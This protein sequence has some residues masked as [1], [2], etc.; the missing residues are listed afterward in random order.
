MYGQYALAI[1]KSWLQCSFVLRMSD[2]GKREHHRQADTTELPFSILFSSLLKTASFF[3]V[4]LM[5]PVERVSSLSVISLFLE[6]KW[7]KGRSNQWIHYIAFIVFSCSQREQQK[8]SRK[9]M[10]Y[11]TSSCNESFLN[12]DA[13]S[14][15]CI[16]IRFP[17][18]TKLLHQ[19]YHNFYSIFP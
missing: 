11:I 5:H 3:L 17:K 9:Q 19:W 1:T 6:K 2:A 8:I 10:L 16:V 14:Q 13:Y 12:V 15:K 7:R 4:S 18:T